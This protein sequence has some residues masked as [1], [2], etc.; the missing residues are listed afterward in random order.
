MPEQHIHF[1]ADNEYVPV[2]LAHPLSAGQK[3]LTGKIFG[4]WQFTQSTIGDVDAYITN[5]KNAVSTLSISKLITTINGLSGVQNNNYIPLSSN[6]YISSLTSKYGNM[7]IIKNSN[8]YT[9]NCI[10]AS[11]TIKTSSISILLPGNIQ[12]KNYGEDGEGQN[13]SN[14]TYINT[15]GIATS[16]I[17]SYT[18]IQPGLLTMYNTTSST[19][20]Q[21]GYLIVTNPGGDNNINTNINSQG[22]QTTG[23]VAS[24]YICTVNIV[25]SSF[26]SYNNPTSTINIDALWKLLNP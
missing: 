26:T 11:S 5:K 19:D 24:N 9:N 17:T 2:K 21:P 14:S 4:N 15:S 8:I 7:E 3:V 18:N 13:F 1:H 6:V 12:V 23:I 10:A 20:I 25:V 16:N 22:I